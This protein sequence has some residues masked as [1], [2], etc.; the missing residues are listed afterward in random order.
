VLCDAE[1]RN[2]AAIAGPSRTLLGI[3]FAS[4]GMPWSS[5]TQRAPEVMA[6]IGSLYD[7]EDEAR[8]YGLSGT[9]LVD[10]RKR[11]QRP[12]LAEGVA[13]CLRRTGPH[14]QTR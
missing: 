13:R 6:F 14:R 11:R 3:R 1:S 5:C 7:N 2:I 8:I 9:D 10:I 4:C 12:V